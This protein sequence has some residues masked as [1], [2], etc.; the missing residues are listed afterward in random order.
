MNRSI[1]PAFV[2]ET[3]ILVESLEEVDVG[4]RPQPI[5][6]TDLEV[7]P[8]QKVLATHI[9]ISRETYEVALV[10]GVTSVVAQKSHRVIGRNVFRMRLDELLR[11]I[12]QSGDG[13][14][15]LV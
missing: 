2:E 3:A 7:R 5:E 8:L 14:D 9:Y 4:F 13:L 12:P 11:T 1:T 6:V 15:V 10:V